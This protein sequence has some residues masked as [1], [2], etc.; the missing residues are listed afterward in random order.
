MKKMFLLQKGLL[1]ILLFLFLKAIFLFLMDKP[2]N[3]D[4]EMNSPL[5]FSYLKQV[6]G[7]Y[8]EITEQFLLEEAARIS[9]AKISQQKITEDYY[10]GVIEEA[11]FLAVAAPLERLLQNEKGFELIYDQYTYIRE[12]PEDRYFLYRNGWDGLLSNET[13][14]LLW[15]LLVLLIVA[16]VFCYEYES[17][18]DR[19]LLTVRKGTFHQSACKIC[20]ALLSVAVLSLLTSCMDLVFYQLKYGLVY[21]DYPLQ[22]LSYFAESDKKCTIFEAFLWVTSGKVFGSL[23]LALLILFV[24]VCMKRYAFTLFACTGI[25]L[26]PYYGFHLESSKYILPAPLGF[27]MST[28][29][30]RGN[31]YSRDPFNDQLTPVFR[32]LSAATLGI[33]IGLSLLLCFIM[34]AVIMFLRSNAWSIKT[35]RLRGK[36]SG[37]LLFMWLTVSVLSGCTSSQ[38]SGQSAVY[39]FSTR[40]SYE[41]N[42]YRLYLDETDL[43]NVH[44]AFE[45][46]QTGKKHEFIR[47]AMSDL[48]QV[49]S[50]L[51]SNGRYVYYMK[52]DSE[53]KRK[54]EERKWFSII[55]VDMS[56]FNEQVVFEKNLS[57]EKSFFIEAK[58]VESYD[59][60]FF[61]SIQAF[62][63]D[64]KNIYFIGPDEI[65]S[66]NRLTGAMKIILRISPIGS[67]AFD[68][69]TIYYVNN[70]SHVIKYD[71]VTQSE[72][73][74]PDMVTR[75]FL[76]KDNKL[77]F[78]NRKDRYKLYTYDLGESVSRKLVDVPVVSFFFREQTI[79]YVNKNDRKEYELKL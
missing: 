6:Q 70:N 51:F 28:G 45:D 27:L 63:L 64:E 12:H 67:L 49:Q 24:S 4:I 26:I 37:T 78:V 31:E 32:E 68:G 50:S 66:I 61:F 1:F 23:Y 62:F 75:S 74:I 72:V 44:I 73:T 8:S 43:N 33:V 15:V 11:E 38:I 53:K 54:F 9:D 65:R 58:K 47:N 55:Q 36:M 79:F 60:A 77:F 25:I 56:T 76:L 39:N 42:N 71:T 40:N 5:Y 46:K 48:T 69:R 21:G 14:D 2:V 20:L 17:K 7:P 30:L 3:P 35:G 59:A 52:Y 22:S 34:L 29:Y 13:L 19:L 41:N 18:M 16:P 10:D 57:L